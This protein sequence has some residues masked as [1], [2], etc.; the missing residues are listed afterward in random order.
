MMDFRIIEYHVLHGTARINAENRLSMLYLN[1]IMIC[2]VKKML[3][4][5]EQQRLLIEMLDKV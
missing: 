5:K 3:T 1:K 4:V 2:Q